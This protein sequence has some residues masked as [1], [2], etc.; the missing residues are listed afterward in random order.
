M[1]TQ[2]GVHGTHGSIR[3]ESIALSRPT[4]ANTKSMQDDVVTESQVT[5]KK[6]EKKYHVKYAFKLAADGAEVTRC[7]FLSRKNLWSSLSE[8]EFKVA[9]SSGKIMVRYA[10]SNPYNNVPASTEVADFNGDMKATVVSG[11]IAILIAV[12]GLVRKR[13]AEKAIN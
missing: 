5:E 2:R 6:G 7:D 11:G 13:R 12:I 3:A 1:T 9:T 8:V 10:T 4:V